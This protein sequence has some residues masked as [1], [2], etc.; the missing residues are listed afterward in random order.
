MKKLIIFGLIAAIV[1]LAVKYPHVML[2]PGELSQGHQ[3]LNNKCYACHTPFGGIGNDKCIACHK[4]S[5]IG[6]DTS[7]TM[8]QAKKVLFH[9]QL[10]NQ[11]CTSCHTDHNGTIP[12]PT[13]TNFEHSLIAQTIVND[14]IK[15][16]QK[17]D[18]RLHK[19]LSESCNKC[20]TTNEWKLSEP[21][22][23]AMITS[24]GRENCTSCHKNPNDS[25]HSTIK[26]NCIKCHDTERWTPSSFNHATYFVLNGDHNANCN[27]CHLNGNFE[28]YTCYGC[29]E[30]TASNIR[31]EH[32]E[33]G[34]SNI[35]DCVACH[36][37]GNEHD[38]RW[39]GNRAR[40]NGSENG[41][42]G[43]REGKG[44]DDD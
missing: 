34:I 20:H 11:T 36:R 31:A 14:C 17:P 26:D 18:D 28:T 8:A 32:S 37:S 5:E 1:L 7:T 25:F 19:Q 22:D 40:Y 13:L 15:C 38:I 39:D 3:D 35:N 29:H 9:E 24:V 4:V 12:D 41:R 27:T 33:E 23:H 43:N 30:H 42:E 10:L 44:D 6:L 21:F 2:N 16:H